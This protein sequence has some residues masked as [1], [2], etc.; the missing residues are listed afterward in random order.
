MRNTGISHGAVSALFLALVLALG[1]GPSRAESPAAPEDFTFKRVKPPGQGT[2]KRITVQI[3][4]AEQAARLAAAP[5]PKK[6]TPDTTVSPAAPVGPQGR[7]T[8]FWDSISPEMAQSGPGRLEPAL[9]ALSE[10]PAGT[11]VSAPRLDTLMA[12]ARAQGRD[13]LMTT[14]GTQVSPALVLAVIAVESAGRADAVSSAGAAG[15]MQLMP[16]T[17]ERFG[18][19]D[20]LVPAQSIRGG[21]A[22][23][24]MLMQEFKGDPIL[25]LA[26]YN[27]GEGAVRSYKGVPPYAETRD[28]VPKVLEAYR[29]ARGLCM[30][31]PMLISDGC[32]FRLPKA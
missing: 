15:L 10:P 6:P 11:G 8:W 25:V 28:Y 4:P 22:F 23:L 12:I 20:R 14:A 7:Y 27:A 9:L 5:K 29:V 13:I 3:D 18:V 16:A 2:K 1:G 30:T 32:V 19:T 24:N 26:G 31:P 17:A 21:V